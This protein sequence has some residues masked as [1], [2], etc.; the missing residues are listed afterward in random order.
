MS[1]FLV[2]KFMRWWDGQEVVR[3]NGT[4]CIENTYYYFSSAV[5][6]YNAFAGWLRP[7]EQSGGTHSFIQG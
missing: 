6:T 7:V 5:L 1:G 2:L 3:A 4:V